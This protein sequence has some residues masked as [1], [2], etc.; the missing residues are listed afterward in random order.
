M[1]VADDAIALLWTGKIFKVAP[2]KP[3]YEAKAGVGDLVLGLLRLH[4]ILEER[5]RP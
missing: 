3:L 2:D 4:E 5:Q 1:V